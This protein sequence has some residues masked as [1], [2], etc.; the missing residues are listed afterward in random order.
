V[1][2][3]GPYHNDEKEDEDELDDPAAHFDFQDLCEWPWSESG[4]GENT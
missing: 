3:P 1:L 4:Y 2:N